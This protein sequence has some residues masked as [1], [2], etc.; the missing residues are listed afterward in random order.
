MAWLRSADRS[1]AQHWAQVFV[2]SISPAEDLVQTFKPEVRQQAAGPYKLAMARAQDEIAIICQTLVK[3]RE[4][5]PFA[6]D[7]LANRINN[8]INNIRTEVLGR[9]ILWI[10]IGDRYWYARSERELAKQLI[11][12]K[13]ALYSNTSARLV[14]F[15]KEG[16]LDNN[17]KL[18]SM[19]G[20]VLL[21][22]QVTQ[23]QLSNKPYLVSDEVTGETLPAMT[24]D[25]DDLYLRLL[26][27]S[28][29]K[30]YVL[31][32]NRLKRL[33]IQRGLGQLSLPITPS[34]QSMKK[35]P[36]DG[37]NE[38]ETLPEK[39]RTVA[40]VFTAAMRR[41][42]LQPLEFISDAYSEALAANPSLFPDEKVAVQIASQLKNRKLTHE[43]VDLL[44][45]LCHVIGRGFE[46]TPHQLGMPPLYQ[47]VFID[48]VQDFTE[49]QVYLM[50]E[51]A[52]PEYFAVTVVG[53]PAQ[54]LHNGS[55]IDVP[56]CFPGK[57]LEKVQLSK[58]MRQSEAPGIA[59]FSA[60]FRLELQR[61]GLGE[62]PDDELIDQLINAPDDVKGPELLHFEEQSQLIEQ[63]IAL[64]KQ[65][66]PM[67]TAVVILPTPELA[68]QIFEACKPRLAEEM[69]DA[70]LSENIDLSRRHVRH[71]TSI[72]NTKGL[73]FDLVILPYLEQYDLMNDQHKNQLY[74]GLTRAKRRLVLIG[75][76]NSP[77][78]IFA[79]IWQQYQAILAMA[80]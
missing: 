20:E 5:A 28:A 2:S 74:V 21:K 75:C 54:K 59:W 51:Q 79:P 18:L 19:S 24:S 53:D 64:L 70:E 30:L 7:G 49:Q 66:K 36:D 37:T 42:L 56:S 47:S 13:V 38:P 50:A 71:F 73:E 10:S 1:I 78:S 32:N 33:A 31:Q 25:I 52:R 41:A 34:T 55:R 27:E 17:L 62:I 80:H 69:I 40:A 29:N 8:C 46:G 60:R 48:E 65:A 6:L 67:E 57:A 11:A 72:T 58:N 43:D 22:E 4:I 26:Q 76:E 35:E 61:S 3:P 14:F 68:T 39:N 12:D 16:P 77:P 9:D 15:D 23:Q 63:T 45:C 44:L